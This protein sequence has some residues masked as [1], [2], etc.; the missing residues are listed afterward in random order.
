MPDTVPPPKTVLEIIL[1]WSADR[2]AWQRD[3]LR[4]IVQ[5]QKLT[6][7]D[8][9]ELV[10]LCKRGRTTD[11][12]ASEPR[13]IPL[14]ALHLPANPGAGAAV[15]LTAI[16]DVSDVNNLAPGQ[17]L[18]F[19]A[20]GIIVVYGDNAAGKSGYA[21]ILKRACRARHTEAILPHVYGD[22]ATTPA[23]ATLCYSVGGVAQPPEAWQDTGKPQPQPH[24]V[25]S[26]VSVLD[27]DCAAVHLRGKNE[28]AFRPFGLDVP[29]ELGDACKRVKAVLEGERRQQASRNAIFTAP[30]WTSTTAVGK[31]LAALTHATDAAA[32]EKLATLTQPEQ[33]RL[34]RL[35]EDLSKNPATAAAEQRLRAERVK[36]LAD[37]LS[38]IATQTADAA[39][40]RLLALHQDGKTKRAAAR[41]AAQ[42]LF[43]GDSLP[44]VGGEVWRTLWDA[45]RR[46]S[47]EIAY[48]GAP[49]PPTDPETLCILCQQP[50]SPE[51]IERMGRF[52]SFI[53]DDTER[54]AQEAEAAFEAALRPLD[55]LAID[56]RPITGSLKEVALQDQALVRLVRRALASARARRYVLRN[57]ISRNDA[58]AIPVAEPFPSAALVKLEA[59]IWQYAADLQNAAAGQERKTLE[60]ERQELADRATLH[61]QMPAI[62]AEIVRLQGIRFLD[63]CLA[64]TTT[65]TITTLGNKIADQIL[66][67]RLRDR[68]AAEII[69]LAG[70][71]VRVEMVRAGG[72]YGSPQYQI[73][74]LAKPDAKVAEILSEGEQTCVAIAAFL[75]ELATAP[76]TSALVFD[77]PITSLDHRWRHKVAQRLVKEAAAR[78]VIVFTHDL[79]FLNDIEDAART[80][81][82][83]ETRHI[84]RSATTV[85]MV[86]DDLP[87]EGMKIAARVDS[88]EKQARALRSVRETADEDSYK[89]EA[90][91]FYDDLRAAWERALE[92]V[93]FAH[94]VMRHRDYIKVQDLAR[95]SALTEQDCQSWA[96]NFGK[97]CGLMAGHDES[98][99]RNRAMPEPDELLRDV[100][101]LDGWVR[102]LRDRQKAIN[103][104]R[105]GAGIAEGRR[106]AHGVFS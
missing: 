104:T 91:H 70:G 67:P 59:D 38:A 78:Q 54:H 32:L 26:A 73:R 41:L 76:H 24:P 16:K 98:R 17:I 83:C 58:T 33:A 47:I 97:C 28:V 53:R 66:T 93:A 3:A 6:D 14:A 23:T 52:E 87:W 101:A 65:N 15:S 89:H 56:L 79:V 40:D 96:D 29:D 88:L 1:D 18:A 106:I 30:P 44:E 68:F 74:L 90:R 62:R 11:P 48:P 71:N 42:E 105:H 4:R 50:L 20:T 60:A 81:T 82:P 36:R 63:D 64:D 92:E 61:T 72:Q 21:R 100:Q 69:D 10:A 34:A 95:V 99:G 49:F 46:Y 37:A 19:P 94:V 35:T 2:P 27:A 57:R 45:A 22:P 31:A 43:H 25:L 5:A 51:A 80:H 102:N 86:N 77:D 9:A 12:S 84:R 8:I 7:G 39:L 75:A 13:A 103:A 85:G 55:E